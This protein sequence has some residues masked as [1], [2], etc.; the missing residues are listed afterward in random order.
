MTDLSLDAR[1]LYA[2]NS[3]VDILGYQPNEVVGKSC[4]EYFHPDEIPF[5]RAIHGRGVQLDKAAVLNYCQIKNR[6]GRWVGCECVFT[7][8][9]DVLVG[10]TSIYKNGTT[11]QRKY[12]ISILSTSVSLI[13]WIERASAAPVI[14]QLFS[15]SPRDPRY[16]M[17]SYISHKFSQ[18]IRPKTHEPRAALFLNRFSRTSTIMYATNG[19]AEVL[20]ITADQLNGKSFYYCIQENCLED[21]VKCLESAKANDSIAYLRFWFRDPR[22]VDQ[23]DRDENMD[24]N[25]SGDD[26]DG[27][28][29]LDDHMDEDGSELA[30]ASDSSISQVG[31][32]IGQ[33]STDRSSVE[34]ESQHLAPSHSS[35]D[36]NSRSSSGNGTDI[37][38]GVNDAVF[39]QPTTRQS[40]TSSL[41]FSTNDDTNRPSTSHRAPEPRQVELEAVVSCTSDG[42]VVVLRRARALVPP[43]PQSSGTPTQRSYTNGCFAS[44][45]ATEPILPSVGRQQYAHADNHHPGRLPSVP[46]WPTVARADTAAMHGPDQEDFMNSIR[47][48]AVFAW[49]LTGINGSLAQYGRGKPTGQ[50]L[51]PGGLPIWK[52][53]IKSSAELERHPYHGNNPQETRHRQHRNISTGDGH[54]S[55]AHAMSYRQVNDYNGQ[56]QSLFGNDHGYGHSIHSASSQ[57]QVKENTNAFSDNAYSKHGNGMKENTNAF[58][59]N[60]YSKHGNGNYGFSDQSYYHGYGDNG[61]SSVR[62][63][64]NDWYPRGPEAGYGYESQDPSNSYNAYQSMPNATSGDASSDFTYNALPYGNSHTYHPTSQHRSQYNNPNAMDSDDT[65]AYLYENL[66]NNG[67]NEA[68]G[69]IEYSWNSQSQQSEHLRQRQGPTHS[70]ARYDSA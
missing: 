45:W 31:S 57:E 32:S 58:S 40:S 34:Q 11:S 41:S 8:V 55:N 7:I 13:A 64:Y 12:M 17:L 2:S 16:H 37:Q 19:L 14:R 67:G 47:E 23:V 38:D 60:A 42:L 51:P 54:L 35:M 3:I 56:F 65:Q 36:P 21:A 6:D 22:Q 10:C 33:C 27:G 30:V 59:D 44:P 26:D 1:L 53:D 25:S 4:W 18:D 69:K 62:V 5:A 28:V 52:H 15:S 24:G 70:Q 63:Q 39:D 29:Q 50:S 49:S 43:S 9:H 66:G 48:V 68:N 46:R 61:E 20:G